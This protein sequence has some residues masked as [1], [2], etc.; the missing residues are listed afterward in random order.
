MLMIR[1]SRFIVSFILIAFGLLAPV[2]A[3]SSLYIDDAVFDDNLG[4]MVR[5]KTIGK[6]EFQGVLYGVSDAL[7]EIVNGEGQVFRILR[8]EI[9][10]VEVIEAGAKRGAYYQDAAANRLIIMPTAFGMDA[11]EF[12]IALQ[13]IVVV[14]ASYGISSN[15]SVWAGVSI[16]GGV[17][18]AR[19]SLGL[20]DFGAFSAGMF[21]GY[22]W[23]SGSPILMPYTVL[24]IGD[25]TDNI[26]I[27]AAVPFSLSPPYFQGVIV[28]IGGKIAISS[29][30]ALIT[31]NWI[32][33]LPGAYGL[34]LM[35]IPS[36]M[37]RI[38]G[39]RFSWDI[40]VIVS[41]LTGW[42]PLPILSF[43]YR[44]N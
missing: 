2:S 34:P 5:M 44:I 30:A 1:Q 16:P 8:S 19:Y 18:S 31:E 36:L 11:G 24:S 41:D 42:I 12:H 28:P 6:G 4:K 14:T 43:T 29:T 35:I 9:N 33:Y 3:Q 7:V 27:G 25:I 13:E 38:A 32:V 15:F 37:F 39:S 17:L 26:T 20:G 21:A 40:G 10:S 22:I 23:L